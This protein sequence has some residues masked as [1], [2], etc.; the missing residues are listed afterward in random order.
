[1]SFVF[2]SPQDKRHDVQQEPRPRMSGATGTNRVGESKR[3]CIS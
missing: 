3:E 2:F 1:M